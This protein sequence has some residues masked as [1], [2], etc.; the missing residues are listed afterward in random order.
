MDKDNGFINEYPLLLSNGNQF[1]EPVA[2]WQPLSPPEG[3]YYQ[4][5]DYRMLHFPPETPVKRQRDYRV[6]HYYE[7][8]NRHDNSPAV[9]NSRT[10][11]TGF[12]SAI[13]YAR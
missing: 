11:T 8:R 1:S 13:P 4:K 6:D 12:M 7:E 10:E 5:D 2:P 3:K 9:V